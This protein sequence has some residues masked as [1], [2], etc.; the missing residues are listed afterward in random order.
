MENH[1]AGHPRVTVS[2]GILEGTVESGSGVRSFKGSSPIG[3][4]ST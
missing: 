1:A 2:G 3:H 4:M